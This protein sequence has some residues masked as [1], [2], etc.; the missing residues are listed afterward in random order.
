MTALPRVDVVV[1]TWND[2]EVLFTALASVAASEGV[3]VHT[4]VVD[5]GSST[6]VSLPP[7]V[8]LIRSEQNLGVA[9]GRNLGARSGSSEF[10][11]FLD[12]DARLHADTLR[13]LSG[14]LVEQ[15]DVAVVGPVF[16]GQSAADSA[17]RAPGFTDK[18][19]RLLTGR[20]SYRQL[21]RNPS[22][23][24]WEVHFV[25]GACQLVRRRAFE[26]VGGLDETY[27]YGPEDV[28]FCLRLRGIG[29]RVVQTSDARCF[30]PPRRRFKGLHTRRGIEHTW[31]VLRHLWRH[32]RSGSW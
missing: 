12:S 14:V 32:R 1:L 17:G 4:I 24:C 26:E 11:C 25:I 29:W 7:S 28:D 31:A 10:V 13:E 9:R 5:N 23:R 18:L 22:D 20:A 19:V 21:A 15:P 3:D 16:D 6:P 2:G 27:F 8:E 30:H